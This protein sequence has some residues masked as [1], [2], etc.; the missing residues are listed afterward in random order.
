L[1]ISKATTDWLDF[2]R[3]VRRVSGASILTYEGHLR[4]FRGYAGDLELE[5]AAAKVES[6]LVAIGRKGAADSYFLVTWCVLRAFFRWANDRQLCV[7]SP[8]RHSKLPKVRRVRRSWLNSQQIERL[9]RA[10]AQSGG[11]HH[12]RDCAML[13]LIFYAALRNSEATGAKLEDLDLE[14]KTLRVYGKGGQ[15]F[16][17][18]LGDRVVEILRAWLRVRPQDSDYLFPSRARHSARCGRLDAVR[19]AKIV[20]E[21][22]EL[23]GLERVTPHT[24]RRS[25]GNILR[26]EYGAPIEVV[27]DLWCHAT[28]TT[29]Q[30]YLEERGLDGLRPWAELG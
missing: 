15:I 13:A 11:M 14:T 16:V 8:L 19:V 22:R 10:A 2:L 5:L 23:A 24:L 4:R 27:R 21:I 30:I 17:K 20:R 18:P 28:I 6:Y 9:L 29:S 25:R 1:R 7:S 26:R 3:F 12:E